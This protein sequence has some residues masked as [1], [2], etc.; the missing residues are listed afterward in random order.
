MQKELPQSPSME[1]KTSSLPQDEIATL[2]NLYH[3]GQMA[4]TEQAC[5][6]LLNTYPQTLVAINL[7]GATLQCQGK[8]QEA[9]QTYNNALQLNPD[10]AE[11]HSNL[12]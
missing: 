3:S 8:L 9:V 6:E 2:L 12:G 4:E 7:L 11:A 10:Y 1:E 5:R